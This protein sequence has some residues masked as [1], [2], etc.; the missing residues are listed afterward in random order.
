MQVQVQVQVPG[1]EL[2]LLQVDLARLAVLHPE[3]VVGDV[4]DVPLGDDGEL[5]VDEGH[6]H[7]AVHLHVAGVPRLHAEP[8]ED[9]HDG[10]GGWD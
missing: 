1:D 3:V 5:E 9:G 2:L 4:V 10:S 6:V 7:G 8:V